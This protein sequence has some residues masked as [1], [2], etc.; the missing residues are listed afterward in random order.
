MIGV[1]AAA[2]LRVGAPPEPIAVRA[3]PFPGL[4]GARD[5]G[6]LSLRA[7]VTLEARAD[8]FGGYSDLVLDVGN[9]RAAMVSDAGH[10]VRFR[11]V[12]DA[13]GDLVGLADAERVPITD[14]DGSV[15]G[16]RD[17][18][19]EGLARL[20]EGFAVTF[21]GDHRVARMRTDGVLGETSRPSADLARTF[22]ANSGLEAL[23][24]MPD[25]TLLAMSEGTDADG[26]AVVLLGRMDRPLA[27]WT[28]AR[29][30]PAP[31]FSV[32][33]AAV[34]P[35][36]GDLFVLERAYSPWRGV[37]MRIVRVPAS[38]LDEDALRG[39][40]LTRMGFLEGVDNMEGIAAARMPDGALRLYLV[41][42]DNF[43]AAQRT[44]ALTLGLAPG[45][46]DGDAAQAPARRD[47]APQEAVEE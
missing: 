29:Y 26:H 5:V 43:S 6:C 14:R 2:L 33:G 25:G 16:K 45:C 19:A 27:E 13:A 28:R 37:R 1:L 3:V 22:G 42:D 4:D 24:A 10:L 38:R 44:V 47:A 31:A 36:T 7:G 21:E 32:T 17:G 11:P 15:L 18:D 12:I 30:R 40:Q 20:G 34:D 39:A 23:T 46:E 9:A 41:S 8:G 35:G